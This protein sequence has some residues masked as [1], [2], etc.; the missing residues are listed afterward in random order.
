MPS[1]N[2]RAGGRFIKKHLDT[3]FSPANASPESMLPITD[4]Q[5]VTVRRSSRANRGTTDEGF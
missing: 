5:R 3:R 1:L 4:T 2:E